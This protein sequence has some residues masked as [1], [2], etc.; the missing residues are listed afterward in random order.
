MD[1][2]YLTQCRLWK[3]TLIVLV[4]TT[5]ILIISVGLL[6]KRAKDHNT[7]PVLNNNCGTCKICTLS[8]ATTTREV[9]EEVKE[10]TIKPISVDKYLS[11]DLKGRLYLSDENTTTYTYDQKTRHITVSFSKKS[12]VLLLAKDKNKVL[13]SKYVS[14]LQFEWYV[15]PDIGKII[16]APLSSPPLSSKEK[17]GEKRGEERGGEET[18]SLGI[19]NNEEVILQENIKGV[20]T[21]GILFEVLFK[22]L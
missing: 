19:N 16:S 12:G 1:T 5:V 2:N 11:R 21:K 6:T 20:F 9:A 3:L 13:L 4:V 10:F 18:Y 15:L 17:R 7:C 14:N 8:S 22:P